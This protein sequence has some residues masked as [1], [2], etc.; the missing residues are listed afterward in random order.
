[1]RGWVGVSASWEALRIGVVIDWGWA[2][3][4]LDD[5]FVCDFLR[6]GLEK[7]GM[8]TMPSAE[9]LILA[10]SHLLCS[11]TSCGKLVPKFSVVCNSAFPHSSAGHAGVRE[12][13]REQLRVGPTP[14]TD[15][16]NVRGEAENEAGENREPCL[17]Q[18]SR[19]TIGPLL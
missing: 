12:G 1:V 7:K 11:C 18:A 9:E 17:F 15:T 6:D 14:R 2:I 8:G 4:G 10:D 13:W 19:F 16:G 5:R 3:R